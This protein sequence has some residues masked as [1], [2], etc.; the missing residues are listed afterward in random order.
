MKKKL[1][2]I[3]ELNPSILLFLYYSITIINCVFFFKTSLWSPESVSFLGYQSVTLPIFGLLIAADNSS[4][5]VGLL[6]LFYWIGS[7]LFLVVCFISTIWRKEYT[8]FFILVLTDIFFTT[9]FTVVNMLQGGVMSLHLLSLLGVI[10][11][12]LLA[13]CILSVKRKTYRENN[14]TDITQDA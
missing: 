12:I 13:I 9:V 2:F 8:L 7:I 6:L 3:W 1:H 4:V 14:N 10:F 5:F 11:D